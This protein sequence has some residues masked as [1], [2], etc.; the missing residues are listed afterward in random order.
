[1]CLKMEE[2]NYN[3]IKLENIKMLRNVKS[4]S[5]SELNNSDGIHFYINNRF[6]YSNEELTCTSLISKNPT[7]FTFTGFFFFIFIM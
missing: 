6:V 1:M 4:K 2:I 3:S 7:R 5:T